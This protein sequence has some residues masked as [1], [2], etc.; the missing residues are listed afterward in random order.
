MVEKFK[1]KL[2]YVIG[3]MILL[4]IGIVLLFVVNKGSNDTREVESSEL[5]N[6]NDN[7]QFLMD[8]MDVTLFTTNDIS[9]G[10]E[11]YE[12][13]EYVG[14]YLENVKQI[15]ETSDGIPKDYITDEML[16]ELPDNIKIFEQPDD[17]V[18]LVELYPEEFSSYEEYL[19][20]VNDTNLFIENNPNHPYILKYKDALS[21]E[22]INNIRHIGSLNDVDGDAQIVEGTIGSLADNPN[23]DYSRFTTGN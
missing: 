15:V 1:N 11:K 8:N 4:I 5:L 6:Y 21:K 10:T 12:L 18:V 13:S 9:I 19:E 20:F 7:N 3:A 14:E 2:Y 23:V 17:K 16:E 22:P